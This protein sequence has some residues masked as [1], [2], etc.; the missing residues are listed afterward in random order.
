MTTRPMKRSAERGFTL[1]ELMIVISLM[2]LLG[3]FAIPAYTGY[4]DDA[5]VGKAVTDIGRI[6]LEI[7][8]YQTNNDGLLPPDLAT[9][10]LG[11]LRDPW[12]RAYI[13]QPM[14]DATPKNQKR[15][16]AANVPLNTDYDLLSRGPDNRS[17]RRLSNT[18]AH[19]DII[20]ASNGAYVGRG[21][22]L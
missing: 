14:T 5:R 18:R 2:A 3:S 15:R 13:Y 20:R 7:Q 16:T 10:N 8:R 12:D 1:M 4:I 22:E 19:D 6:S 11:D 9:I 17:N 21:D